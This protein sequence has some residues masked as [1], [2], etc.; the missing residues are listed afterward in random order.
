MGKRQIRIFRSSLEQDL[1][2]RVGKPVQVITTQGRV[3]SGILEA[4]LHNTLAIRDGRRFLH[5]LPF[6]HV[7]EV[8]LDLEAAQ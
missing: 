8:V 4:C 3:F 1:P 2:P 6:G 5:H 7:E